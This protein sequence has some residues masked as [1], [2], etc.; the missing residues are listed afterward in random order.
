MDAARRADAGRHRRVEP[1]RR[2]AGTG[3]GEADTS[4]TRRSAPGR[5]RAAWLP[6]SMRC[7]WSRRSSDGWIASWS[8]RPRTGGSTRS[9]PDSVDP[10]SPSPFFLTAGPGRA[11]APVVV[12]TRIAAWAPIETLGGVLVIDAHDEAYR[13]ERAP[14]WSAVDVLIERASRD[15]APCV[16]VTPC[17][18]VSLL[19]GA[20]AGEH[21][22]RPW[23]DADGRRS[24]WWIAA[25]TIPE[26]ACSPSASASCSTRSCPAA[27]P[28][29]SS[30]VPVG[31]ACWPARRAGRWPV[32][33]GAG[34]ALEQ[35]D[36]GGVLRCRRCGLE[37]PVVCAVCDSTR[38]KVLRMGVGRAAE[39][40]SALMG[41]EAVEI[42]RHL[43]A[44]GGFARL[45][46][47]AGGGDRGGPA[48][49]GPGRRR[50]LPRLRP[51]PRWLP[52]RGR[53]GGPG[54][55]G[56]G[57]PG[58]GRAGSAGGVRAGGVR[59]GGGGEAGGRI[60]IQTRLPG[61]AALAAAVHADPSRLTDGERE[62]RPGLGL[63]P[64]RALA[65]LGGPAAEEMVTGLRSVDGLSVSSL[66]EE[67][68]WSRR[69]ITPPCATGW[70]RFPDRRAE[71]GWRS[72][73]PT[74]EP[75][76]GA[77]LSSHLR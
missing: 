70:P 40:L 50:C 31:R 64:F 41:M 44:R 52:V 15:A 24:R 65:T 3:S 17:P 11:G 53:R 30:T 49:G 69:P 75:A 61:H 76:N 13:E 22:T 9:R 46:R 47:P 42:S 12:G 10:D 7:C 6:P 21:V 74:C 54:P 67:N 18:T 2:R 57:C 62:L 27:G 45:G 5:R 33:P 4:S 20:S 58:G 1:H 60:L 71:S 63:P 56:P 37:R 68:G 59:A 23:S 16:L 77:G 34:G 48:P 14:T 36:A 73:P 35:Q 26:P 72:I 28:S 19:D 25:G 55:V 39:E 51:A 29:A 32:A 38:M 66:A 43:P 8:W